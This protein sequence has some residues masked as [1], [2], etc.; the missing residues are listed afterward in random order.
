[1]WSALS[2]CFTTESMWTTVFEVGLCRAA[3]S[4]CVLGVS[5]CGKFYLSVLPLTSPFGPCCLRSICVGAASSMCVFLESVCL[6]SFISLFY[7]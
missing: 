3:S 5:P 6:V 1:M 2:V 4:M 7:H